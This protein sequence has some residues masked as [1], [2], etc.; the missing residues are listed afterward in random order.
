MSTVRA[1]LAFKIQVSDLLRGVRITHTDLRSISDIELVLTA[2]IDRLDAAVRAA[3]S[4]AEDTEDVFAP[5]AD[6]PDAIVPPA[7]WTRG[8]R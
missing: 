6:A 1:A 3:T 8:W 2:C 5:G 4:Y 7:R